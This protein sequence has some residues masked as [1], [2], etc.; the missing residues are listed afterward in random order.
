M[1]TFTVASANTYYM[2]MLREPGGFDAQLDAL[3]Y[4]G[5]VELKHAS[6]E[7][8]ASDHR[9]IVAIFEV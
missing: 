3:L 1:S 9:A 6:V 4:R 2:Q 7:D 8:I 5:D